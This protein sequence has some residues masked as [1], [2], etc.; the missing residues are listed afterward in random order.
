[1]S[2]LYDNAT[3]YSVYSCCKVIFPVLFLLT[4]KS[5][6]RLANYKF[7]YSGNNEKSNTY[8]EFICLFKLKKMILVY[9]IITF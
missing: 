2:R 6:G 4:R 9:E 8:N 3:F 1:M 5:G 7:T